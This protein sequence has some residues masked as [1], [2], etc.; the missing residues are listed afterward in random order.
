MSRND[1]NENKISFYHSELAISKGHNIASVNGNQVELTSNEFKILIYLA[2]NRNRIYS[3]EQLL[4]HCAIAVNGTSEAT[5]G[6]HQ[7][8][9]EV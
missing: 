9:I 5:F 4:E 2:T 1:Q 7:I 6:E 3:R 8:N